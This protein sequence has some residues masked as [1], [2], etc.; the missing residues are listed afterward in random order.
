MPILRK[1]LTSNEQIQ[2]KHLQLEDAS[3]IVLKYKKSFFNQEPIT[4]SPKTQ[5]AINLKWRKGTKGISHKR[6]AFV[7]C[8]AISLS[9]LTVGCKYNA[10]KENQW[11]KTP[12]AQ[13][14]NCTTTGYSPKT[15]YEQSKDSIAIVIAENQEG[16]ST[17]SGFAIQNK[18]NNT[19]II[20]NSHVVHGA[21]SITAKWK[22]GASDKAV[23][24]KDGNGQVNMDDLA[25]IEIKDRIRSPLQ[26]KRT[27]ASIGESIYAIGTPGLDEG[28]LDFSIT[29]GIL[30][31]NDDGGRILQFDTPINSG[32]SGGPLLDQTGCVV[33]IATAKIEQ[34]GKEGI[35]FGIASKRIIEFTGEVEET[36]LN[37]DRNFY[38]TKNKNKPA[39]NEQTSEKRV[40]EVNTRTKQNN[41]KLIKFPLPVLL[42]IPGIIIIAILATNLS[43]P[44][45]D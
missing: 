1:S 44:E 6:T 13:I 30:S 34:L 11:K 42:M 15:V 3:M 33:G 31:R 18:N 39:T 7:A 40:P 27:E 12:P 45:E 5:Q 32:N 10:N 25:I 23:I 9:M 17:G 8:T 26:I 41:A 14:S 19:Q 35:G 16:T 43:S 2:P 20:T 38:E 4:M 24:I 29:A 22:D 36:Q 37:I 28:L 21:T